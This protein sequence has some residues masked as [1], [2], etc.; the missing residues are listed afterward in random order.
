MSE[1]GKQRINLISKAIVEAEVMD[2]VTVDELSSLL[3]TLD[4]NSR[5]MPKAAGIVAYIKKRQSDGA[6][7]IEAFRSAFPS[8]CVPS[9]YSGP[10]QFQNTSLDKL[11]KSTIDIKAKRLENTKLYKKIFSL[12][13]TNIYI[14]YAIERMEVLDITLNKI[15]DDRISERDRAQLIKVFLEVTA[16]PEAVKDV[17]LN[18]NVQNNNISIVPLEEKLNGI[19]KALQGKS[20]HE[21]IEVLGSEPNG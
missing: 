15:R 7:R 2:D 17:E 18:I 19:S 5:D 1:R 4:I 13:Q 8:R 14:A 21:V 20:A 11:S 3:E 16:K 10:V 6:G 9:D 12:L